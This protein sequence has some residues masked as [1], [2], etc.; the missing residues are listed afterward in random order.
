[1][2]IRDLIEQLEKIEKACP[3]AHVAVYSRDAGLRSLRIPPNISYG[4]HREG[5]DWLFCTKENG[6]L[7]L[8][9]VR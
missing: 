1:M 9:I 5:I 8:L 3:D 7:D 4:D 6:P 2:K